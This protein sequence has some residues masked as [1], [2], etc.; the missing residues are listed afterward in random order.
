MNGTFFLSCR[1][2][3]TGFLWENMLAVAR[4]SQWSEVD[5]V[6]NCSIF[7][8]CT[9]FLTYFWGIHS[10]TPHPSPPLHKEEDENFQKWLKWGDEKCL[11][12]MAASQG[13]G[14]GLVNF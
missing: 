6:T 9:I 5:P 1:D 13:W 8:Y 10:P 11:L 7:M 2:K 14:V 3:N 4:N 12:E